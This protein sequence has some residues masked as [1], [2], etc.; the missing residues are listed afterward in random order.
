MDVEYFMEHMLNG[1]Y[2][3]KTHKLGGKEMKKQLITMLINAL[4]SILTP[5]LLKEFADTAVGFAEAYVLGS[6]STLD[7]RI[8][9][10]LCGAIRRAFDI[11]DDD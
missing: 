2:L 11:P 1:T 8:V 9:L 4:L 6:K 10:P 3:E 5:E 7:D